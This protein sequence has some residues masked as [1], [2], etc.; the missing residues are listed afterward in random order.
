[1]DCLEYAVNILQTTFE[2]FFFTI[3][4]AHDSSFRF[5]STCI[6]IRAVGRCHLM[7]IT[8]PYTNNTASSRPIDRIVLSFNTSSSTGRWL[9]CFIGL[10]SMQSYC[11]KYIVSITICHLPFGRNNLLDQYHCSAY[12]V[13]K[14]DDEANRYRNKQCTLYSVHTRTHERSP[15]NRMD[16]FKHS[17]KSK[18]QM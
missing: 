5:I 6:I 7:Y 9:L 2:H 15:E 1:M 4:H 16:Q 8:F 12:D 11:S 17:R 18:S 3:C 14:V 13:Y 10:T